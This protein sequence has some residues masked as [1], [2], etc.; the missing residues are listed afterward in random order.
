MPG[1]FG[2]KRAKWGDAVAS[3]IE[4]LVAGIGRREYRGRLHPLLLARG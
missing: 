2:A 3:Q 1:K 4:R